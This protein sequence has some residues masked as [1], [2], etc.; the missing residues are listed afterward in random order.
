MKGVKEALETVWL[1]FPSLTLR[2]MQNGANEMLRDVCLFGTTVAFVT[3]NF[4]MKK[5]L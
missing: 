5:A 1:L 2:G 4:Q 3:G